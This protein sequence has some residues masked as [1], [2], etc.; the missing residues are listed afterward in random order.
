MVP[1][2]REEEEVTTEAGFEPTEG[3]VKFMAYTLSD[4]FI[5]EE[6]QSSLSRRILAMPRRGCKNIPMPSS[7]PFD[8]DV[9]IAS[10]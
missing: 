7:S 10:V 1:G 8:V 9:N 4:G 5:A 6:Q 3:R 2:N